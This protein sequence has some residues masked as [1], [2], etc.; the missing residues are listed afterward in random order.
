VNKPRKCPDERR[1]RGVFQHPAAVT[2]FNFNIETASLSE[3]E[4]RWS[5]KEQGARLVFQP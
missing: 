5:A 1:R 2:S 3:I 4:T